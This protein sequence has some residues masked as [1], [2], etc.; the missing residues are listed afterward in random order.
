MKI[1]ITRQVSASIN[2]CELT[3]LERQPID[4]E[5]AR[6]Q[7]A[8]YEQALRALG[9]EVRR[10]P[11]LDEQPDAVFV[12]DVALVLDECAILTNPGAESRRPEVASIAGVLAPYREIFRIQSPATLDGGDVLLVGHTLYVGL[13]G[14]SNQPAIEQLSLILE[15]VNLKHASSYQIRT[16]EVN[17]CLHLKSAVTQVQEGTLLINPA[18]VREGDFPGMRFIRIDP[19]EPYAANTL[20]VDGKVIYPAS[21]PRTGA[22]LTEA[23]IDV[24]LVD[25]D[26]LAK[27]EGALTC[28]SLVFDVQSLLT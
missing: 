21:F 3:H 12:E 17:G 7:H 16:V 1:A 18:W 28:C 26:E 25:A 2:Q 27:A 13:S 24:I 4:L 15:A 19:F 5:R 23:G 14:R 8:Q 10:L 22:R 11:P 20:R 9:V 6:L